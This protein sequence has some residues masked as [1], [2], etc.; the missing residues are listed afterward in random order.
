M[1]RLF[2]KFTVTRGD[3]EDLLSLRR[4]E[5][6]RALAVRLMSNA[7]PSTQPPPNESPEWADL[8]EATRLLGIATERWDQARKS[9]TSKYP[10]A[11]RA[12]TSPPWRDPNACW[13]HCDPE[14]WYSPCRGRVSPELGNQ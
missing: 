6:R 9:Y 5:D 14:G 8:V 3:L 12:K 1:D 10:V 4:W 11:D 13:G 7:T 2:D